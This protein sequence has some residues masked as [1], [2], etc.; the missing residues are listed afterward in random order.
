MKSIYISLPIKG[1][2]DSYEARL[3]AAVAYVK[4]KYPE[5]DRIVT[6]KELAEAVMDSMLKNGG[7]KPNYEDYLTADIL[8]IYFFCDAIFMC[9]LWSQSKGCQAEY[10]FARAIGIDILYQL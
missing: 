4:E 7:C 1:R 2:E 3:N 5:Y 8:G 9:R 10:A 6:P